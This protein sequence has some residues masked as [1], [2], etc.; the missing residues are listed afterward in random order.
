M[1]EK[2][3][4]RYNISALPL[5]HTVVQKL[6]LTEILK[7]FIP[8][9]G[10][11]TIHVADTITLL[12]YNLA[13]GKM[14]LYKLEEW[15]RSIDFR[16]LGYLTAK[17]E[18]YTDDRFG[19]A[20]DK[21]Y[22]ADRASLMTSIVLK[23]VKKFNI[24]L[25]RIHN[26]STS[27]KAYGKI[28]GKTESGIELKRGHSKDHRPDLKQIIF[29]LSISADGGIPVHQKTYSGNRTDDTTHIETWNSLCKICDSFNFLYVAD[30]KLATDEQLDHIV[31]HG[32]RAVTI[33]PKTWNEVKSFKEKLSQ[34][35]ISKKEILRRHK[36][37]NTVETEYF[38][39]FNGD[40]LTTKKQYRIHW[41]FSSSKK[42]R[43][44]SERIVR[45]EKTENLLT[46]LNSKINTYNLKTKDQIVTAIQSI[47]AKNGTAKLFDINFGTTLESE[48]K[49]TTPGRPGPNTKHEK[50][51]REIITLQWSRNKSQITQEMKIDGIFPLLSTDKTLSAKEVLIAYKY[52][53]RL[54]KRFTQFKSIHNAAPLLFN[55]IERVE[56]N[57]F[58]FFMALMV[59]AL[60]EREVRTSMKEKEIERIDVY[61]EHRCSKSPTSNAIFELF[62]SVSTYQILY[63]E[64]LIEE[65]KDD[66]NDTQN[67][68]LNL[69][70]I[71][72]EKYWKSN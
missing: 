59:Q 70:K 43:D 50:I 15:C 11:E 28:E 25:S 60:V 32:G 39:A 26:D 45:L 33:M 62:E 21:L 41:I 47:F 67:L 72:P 38:S 4:N 2:T 64:E 46:I 16:C 51:V 1:T 52:Q 66:L 30:S 24:N 49:Q 55:N 37:G 17:G 35:S 20:L 10:N 3:H 44:R 19:R 68:I 56:A 69:L 63:G 6:A 18:K 23:A 8:T 57:M 14:P 53:P 58:V 7:E 12:I 34:A 40:Y 27:V 42:D 13:L 5:L 29:S 65:F 31:T 36:P 61:P 9:H 54:E 22:L 71:N 48:R